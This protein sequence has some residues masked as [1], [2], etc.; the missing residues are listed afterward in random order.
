MSDVDIRELASRWEWLAA[1]PVMRQLRTHLDEDQ[2]LD[3]LEQMTADGYRL[4]GLFADGDLAALAGVNIMTN[5]YYGRHLWVF[6]LVTDTDHRSMGYGK[7]LFEHI[8]DWADDHGCEKVALSSGLQ[9]ERAHRFYE[10]RVEMDRAS[11]VYTM[12]LD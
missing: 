7:R 6:E 1:F 10:D 4:F 11:Y 3:Y 9:R 5:M 12:E 8:V 2:Y